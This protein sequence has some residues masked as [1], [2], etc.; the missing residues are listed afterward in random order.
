[1]EEETKR[2]NKIIEVLFELSKEFKGYKEVHADHIPNISK[3]EIIQICSKPNKSDAKIGITSC[4]NYRPDLWCEKKGNK[5]DIFEVWDS[6]SQEACV[7]D[8]LFSAL[9]PNIDYLCI[10]CFNEYEANIAKSLTKLILPHLLNK[11]ENPLLD[12]NRVL[13]TFIS[14]EIL[15]DK[16]KLKKYLHDELKF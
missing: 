4:F 8:V 6:Q 1:M 5:I 12:Q 13:V 2:H 14:E 11:N 3:G 7:E 15:N 10:I 16:D 9:A